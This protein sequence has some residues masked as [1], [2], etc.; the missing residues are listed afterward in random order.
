VSDQIILAWEFEGQSHEETL[1]LDEPITIGRHS[2][3]DIVLNV[4]TISRQQA[5]IML[6]DDGDIELRNLS[7]SRSIEV[8]GDEET[9]RLSFDESS[10]LSAGSTFRIDTVELTVLECILEIQ[11][12]GE[13]M[14]KCP[15][16][17]R[18]L[19]PHLEECP[20]DGWSLAAATTLYITA[21]D[22]EDME[23][24]NSG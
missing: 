12:A 16:C 24:E 6:R 11:G 17:G 1:S 8:V 20:Y 15:K 19:P 14:V 13:Q 5:K 9:I 18:A 10:M 3:C 21:D 7:K 23:G 4:P 22:L 2:A